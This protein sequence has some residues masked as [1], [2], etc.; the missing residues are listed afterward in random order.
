MHRKQAGKSALADPR[1]LVEIRGKALPLQ[2][3]NY[4]VIYSNISYQSLRSVVLRCA[5][6]LKR[7]DSPVLNETGN[8]NMI[9][10]TEIFNVQSIAANQNHLIPFTLGSV[11]W[12]NGAVIIWLWLAASDDAQ[13]Q[14]DKIK[15]RNQQAQIQTCTAKGICSGIPL[16][17]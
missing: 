3:I 1:Q 17:I 11:S 15:K 8:K 4:T 16:E 2:D 7:P 12:F 14:R 6:A 13:E 9:V 10:V 5:A